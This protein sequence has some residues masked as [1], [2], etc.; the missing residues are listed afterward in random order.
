MSRGR[1]ALTD[2]EIPR[3]AGQWPDYLRLQMGDYRTGLVKLP[4]PD[5]MRDCLEA[6]AGIPSAARVLAQ[7][8]VSA[9]VTRR[10][11]TR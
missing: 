10:S 2:K 11:V 1:R 8:V 6:L 4:Q 3:L 5:K 7:R 9:R